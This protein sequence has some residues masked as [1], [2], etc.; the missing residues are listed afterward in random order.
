MRI[1]TEGGMWWNVCHCGRLCRYQG[2]TEC[3]YH[4][5]LRTEAKDPEYYRLIKSVANDRWIARGRK[6]KNVA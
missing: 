2:G 3:H 5:K 6:P 4:Q 1:L